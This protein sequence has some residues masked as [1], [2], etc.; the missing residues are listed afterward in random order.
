MNVDS[1]A[2]IIA[3]SILHPCLN[4][5]SIVELSLSTSVFKSIILHQNELWMVPDKIAAIAA[6]L[7]DNQSVRLTGKDISNNLSPKEIVNQYRKEIIRKKDNN[8]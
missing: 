7:E 5:Q 8:F 1:I 6:G 3:P 2:S 4:E